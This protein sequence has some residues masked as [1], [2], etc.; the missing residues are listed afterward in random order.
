MIE[1]HET[2]SDDAEFLRL[3]AG[4]IDGLAEKG[5]PRELHVIHIDNWFDHKWLGFSGK[6]LGA[7]GVWKKG[8]R[9]TAPAFTPKRVLSHQYFSRE[10]ESGPFQETL[11]PK[12]VHL[13]TWS[14]VNLQRRLSE[15]VHNAV[16]VW[17]TS[18]TKANRKGAIMAY[19]FDGSGYDTWYASLTA[20][21]TWRTDRTK[22]I[23]KD[24]FDTLLENAAPGDAKQTDATDGASPCC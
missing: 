1:V 12:G 21:G 9:L 3:V 15:I 20:E 17:Y 14:A 4:V 6:A 23:T 7:V 24:D 18:N 19:V 10:N 16:L 11:P 5:S 13:D 8:E 22:G 2:P